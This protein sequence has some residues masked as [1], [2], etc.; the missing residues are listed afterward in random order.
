MNKTV[1]EN[2]LSPDKKS[3]NVQSDDEQEPQTTTSD[4]Y[5]QRLKVSQK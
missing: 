3:I 4:L 1:V 5:V 2:F